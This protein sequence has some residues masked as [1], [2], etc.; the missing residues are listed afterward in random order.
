MHHFAHQERPY[1]EGVGGSSPSAPTYKSPGHGLVTGARV[2][3]PRVA[4]AHSWHIW[5]PILV[6]EDGRADLRRSSVGRRRSVGVEPEHQP[7]VGVAEPMLHGSGVDSVGHPPG[8]GRVAQPV[9]REAVEVGSF[10]GRGEDPTAEVAVR[11]GPPK[12]SANSSSS[13]PR[14][15]RSMWARSSSRSGP[16]MT[17]VRS[18]AVVFGSSISRRPSTLTTVRAMV[19]VACSKSRSQTWG[20]TASPKRRPMTPPR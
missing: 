10:D 2:V 4:M 19:T 5:S 11:S 12:A 1:K 13:S 8:G 3:R 7:G 14:S 17:R 16:G 9:E 18:P 20:A 15:R 6:P